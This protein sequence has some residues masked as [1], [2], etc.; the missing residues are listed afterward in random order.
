MWY[1]ILEILF[2]VAVCAGTLYGLDDPGGVLRLIGVGSS[3]YLLVRGFDNFAKGRS[4]RKERAEALAQQSASK[5]CLSE[6]EELEPEQR[7]S[8]TEEEINWFSLP[9]G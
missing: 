3:I 7:W 4:E 9:S 2:A 8:K 6:A 1:A 5:P